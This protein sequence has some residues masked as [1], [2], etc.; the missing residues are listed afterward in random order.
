MGFLDFF[1]R[2]KRLEDSSEAAAERYLT[3]T[4]ET[5]FLLNT[6]AADIMKS[7]DYAKYGFASQL[8][9]AA[10]FTIVET[11][12]AAGDSMSDDK[13]VDLIAPQFQLDRQRCAF[14]VRQA[15]RSQGA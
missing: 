1:K 9:L 11:V 13:I 5:M 15:R 3:P 4:P 6:A 2:T 12:G 14:F 10:A 8:E 7:G